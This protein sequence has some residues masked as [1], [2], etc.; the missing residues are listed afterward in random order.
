MKIYIVGILASAL[1]ACQT[2][3]PNHIPP[4]WQ[5]PGAAAGNILENSIYSGR[6]RKVERYTAAHYDMI[7]TDINSGGGAAL[8]KAL[9]LARVR[10]ERR[11]FVI[12]EINANPDVYFRGTRA[13]NI[14]MLV[15]VF[16]VHSN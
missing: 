16:M 10:S 6:R 15:V 14:E 11:G 2:D 3:S 12:E 4:L 7:I 13:E 8:T 9:D 1:S 5:L